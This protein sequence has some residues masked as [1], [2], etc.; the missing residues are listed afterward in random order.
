[1]RN[2]IQQLAAIGFL[3]ALVTTSAC[4]GDG[5]EAEPSGSPTPTPFCTTDPV[6]ASEVDLEL[7]R[8]AGSYTRHVP[9]E[10]WVDSSPGRLLRADIEGLGGGM[11]ASSEV[12]V[13]EE[14]LDGLHRVEGLIVLQSFPDK[15]DA[16]FTLKVGSS[17]V[18]LPIVIGG[19][20]P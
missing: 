11:L 7:P 10:G 8:H 20:N 13:G 3:A 1:V 15:Q 17:V 9:V 4:G 5:D 14:E 2:A 18:R 19:A 6:L 16:C 12:E